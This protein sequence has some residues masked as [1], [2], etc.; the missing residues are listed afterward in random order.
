[1]RRRSAI[2]KLGFVLSGLL[3]VTKLF[4]HKKLTSPQNKLSVSDFGKKFTWGTATA[5]YQIEAAHDD[6]GKSP[7]I[8]DTF[9]NKPRR[10]R[11]IGNANNAVN[12]YHRY[13]QDLNIN[14]NLNFNAFRFSLSWSRILPDGTGKVNQKGLDF[15]HRVI[16]TCLNKGMEPWMTIYHWDLPQILED[17]GGWTNRN[18]VDWFAEYSSVVTKAFGD[19]VKNWCVLNEP[20]SFVGLGYFMGYH[21][22]GK[23]GVKNFLPA[24]HHATLCQAEGGRIIRNNV[25]NANIGSTFSTSYVEPLKEKESHFK[26]SLRMDAVLNRLF[27]EPALG[28]GYPYDTIPALDQI[29]KHFLSGDEEKM[30]FDFDFIGVQYYFRTIA[31]FSLFPPILFARDVPARRRDVPMNT[32]QLEVYPHGLYEILR[33]FSAYDQIKKLV[34]TESGVC[35]HDT[36]QD[37]QVHDVKRINYFQE[38]LKSLKK[39]KDEGVPV[40]GF[41]AW[42]LMDNFEWSEGFEPRFGLVYVDHETNERYVKDSGFWFKEFLNQDKQ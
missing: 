30:A 17:K 33:K 22:P 39:A 35:F 14:K 9:T 41:F 21:A 42:T 37:G 31:R 6:D 19:K 25:R 29:E 40:D 15:Y 36:F 10:T 2:K 32:M 24:A 13:N 8:W 20:M 26:A 28:M 3:S 16:D 23:R 18:I 7:S 38:T 27:L 11:D 34:V 5:A 12:F 4:G 1:M